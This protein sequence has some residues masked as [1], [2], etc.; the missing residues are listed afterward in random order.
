MADKIKFKKNEDPE[1]FY[2]YD[3]NFL[4]LSK[5]NIMLIDTTGNI[6]YHNSFSEVAPSIFPMLLNFAVQIY[7]ASH[8]PFY[9]PSAYNPPV[10]KNSINTDDHYY[11]FTKDILKNSR[12]KGINR[13]NKKTGETINTF[14]THD[15]SIFYTVDEK[16]SQIYIVDQKKIFKCYKL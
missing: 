9:F 12:I 14:V 6:V 13:I 16:L 10:Y 7:L 11:V 1:Y 2:L 15:K 3:D 4:F 8:D 5:Q